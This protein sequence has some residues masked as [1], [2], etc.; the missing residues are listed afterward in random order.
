[1]AA[2][3][4][5]RPALRVAVIGTGAM[6]ALFGAALVRTGAELVCFDRSADVIG[7]IA[8]DGL[9]IDGALGAHRLHPRATLDAAAIGPVDLALVTVD[10]GATREAAEAAAA[11]LRPEGFALTLQNG[12]GNVE[13]LVAR[14]GAAR[15]AAG[16]TYNS[17]AGA[18]PGRAIHTNVGPT[19]IGEAAGGVSARLRDIA[20]RFE[21]QSMPTALDEAVMGHVW[22]KFVHNCA[23]NPI[24]AITGLRPAEIARTPA[25]AELLDRALD[26]ILAVVDAEGVVLPETDARASIRDHC[27]ERYNRP[28]MLQHLLAGRRTEI[29]ALNGALLR[30]A[31][32]RGVAVPFNTAIV[33]AVRALEA[34]GGVRDRSLDE[35]ALE[36]EARGQ[37][38]GERWGDAGT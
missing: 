5:D 13:R 22:S 25:A 19:V 32:A 21:S 36:A 10:S 12:I 31:A 34:A 14:L 20:E 11:C 2:T 8:R 26:E 17:G 37:P 4:A 30:H 9:R 1:M 23:I 18:G 24:S 6:G 27:W 7:A 15:V 3:P 29:D 38:R 16:I 35:A 28:S 33:L